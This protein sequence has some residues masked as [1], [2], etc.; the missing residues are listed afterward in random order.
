MAVRRPCA[1]VG[2]LVTRDFLV[3]KVFL[4][5]SCSEGIS[6]LLCIPSLAVSS[7]SVGSSSPECFSAQLAAGASGSF[8]AC[9]QGITG[10]ARASRVLFRRLET[11]WHLGLQGVARPSRTCLPHNTHPGCP[12]CVGI[13]F[14]N[15]SELQTQE[16][17]S[18]T[19][20]VSQTA[21]EAA[22]FAAAPRHPYSDGQWRGSR[23]LSAAHRSWRKAV[24]EFNLRNS[25]LFGEGSSSGQGQK[26]ARRAR[27]VS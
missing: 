2:R 13:A 11:P 20:R 1:R 23:I 22:C 8:W 14:P 21:C 26:P 9:L 12:Q 3:A 25:P 16:V 10:H 17:S 24:H 19:E 27:R 7:I 6:S 18:H 5:S 15:C 4:P